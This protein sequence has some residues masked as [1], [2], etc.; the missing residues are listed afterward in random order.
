M[1]KGGFPPEF[2][3]TPQDFCPVGISSALM[4][5]WCVKNAH[6]SFTQPCFQHLSWHNCFFRVFWDLLKLNP[7]EMALS[8][9]YVDKF[10]QCNTVLEV[11]CEFLILID[12]QTSSLHPIYVYQPTCCF[13]LPGLSFRQQWWFLFTVTFPWPSSRRGMYKM[14]SKYLFSEQML[15]LGTPKDRIISEENLN[16]F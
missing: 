6:L 7:M 16:F 14:F 3:F 9:V 1:K 12:T 15:A 5:H 4:A 13:I 8:L 10:Y 11:W 2:V